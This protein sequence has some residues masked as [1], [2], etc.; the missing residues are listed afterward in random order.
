MS[1]ASFPGS[2][3]LIAAL[4]VVILSALAASAATEWQV[5]SNK[6]GLL[7]ERRA[8]DGSAFYEVRATTQ[9]S[10][11][12][13]AIFDTVWRQ[14][15]HPQFVP[16][17][18]R[19]DLLA[20]AGDERVAYEQIEIPLARDRDYTVRLQRRVDAEAQ[21]YEI[22]FVTANEAGPP[23]D[24]NHI[25]IP[26]IRGRW[27]IEPGPEG[28]GAAVRYEVLSDP[29]GALPTWVVNQVQGEAVA[30][31]VRSMLQRTQEKASHK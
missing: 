9:T 17:L 22:V 29:G 16:Y 27:L 19:L 24:R 18:K 21:R 23:P 4:L 12:P 30:R 20:E 2:A 28:R 25:R 6:D 5:L 26:S 7:I 1:R 8:S 15:D 3:G 14:Q 10:L 11:S 31:L 13:A